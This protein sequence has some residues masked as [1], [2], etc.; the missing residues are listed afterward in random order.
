MIYLLDSVQTNRKGIKW[1][2]I[3]VTNLVEAK[4]WFQLTYSLKG[5]K[6]VE[7]VIFIWSPNVLGSCLL[8]NNVAVTYISIL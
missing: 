2:I 6:I 1:G 3:G 7:H 5:V 8:L 4:I